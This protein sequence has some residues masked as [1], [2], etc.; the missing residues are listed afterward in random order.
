MK[1]YCHV[2][3]LGCMCLSLSACVTQVVTTPAQ[4]ATQTTQ[5]AAQTTTQAAQMAIPDSD[6]EKKSGLNSQ[7]RANASFLLIESAASE[8]KNF[9]LDES[10]KTVGDLKKSGRSDQ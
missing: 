5:T 9:H 2:T 4:A 1:F 10:E 8:S 7:S 3:L 6:D